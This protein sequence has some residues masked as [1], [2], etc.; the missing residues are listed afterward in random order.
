MVCIKKDAFIMLP[1]NYRSLKKLQRSLIHLGTILTLLIAVNLDTSTSYAAP[2]SIPNVRQQK[3]EI[4]SQFG[5]G[6]GRTAAIAWHEGYLLVDAWGTSQTSIYDLTNLS[7]PKLLA[8]GLQTPAQR[9][10]FNFRDGALLWPASDKEFHVL[11]GDLYF[12]HINNSLSRK[13]TSSGVEQVTDQSIHNRLDIPLGGEFRNAAIEYWTRESSYYP[14]RAT[15]FWYES[16]STQSELF[17]DNERIASW[18]HRGQTGVN[19][20]GVTLG[21]YLIYMAFSV[22][23]VNNDSPGKGI[24]IYDMR[25][26]LDNP[27]TPPTLIGY[28][29]AMIGGYSPVLWGG[30]GKLKAF[31]GAAQW[32]GLGQF[33]TVDITDLSNPTNIKS[34]SLTGQGRNNNGIQ[35]QRA[36]DEYMYGAYFKINMETNQFE[37]LIFEQ[38]PNAPFQQVDASQ[39]ALPVGNLVFFGGYPINGGAQGGVTVVASQEE[40]DTRGP[41]V[42]FHIPRA[43]EVNYHRKAPLSVL[44]H[45]TLRQSTIRM[46]ETIKIRPVAPNGSLGEPIDAVVRFSFDNIMTIDPRPLGSNRERWAADT[47]YE[48]EFVANGIEDAAGN[49]MVQHK[50]RFSTGPNLIGEAGGFDSNDTPNTGTPTSQLTL[51]DV[52]VNPGT[53]MNEDSRVNFSIS[54]SGGNSTKTFTWSFDDGSTQITNSGQVSHIYANPGTYRISVEVNDGTTPRFAFANI[55]VLPNPEVSRTSANSAEM[56][57]TSDGL[58]LFTVNPDNDSITLINTSNNQLIGELRDIC[59]APTSI[60]RDINNMVWVACEKDDKVLILNSSGEKVKTI[61]LPW[62]TRPSAIV[63]I[64]DSVYLTTLLRAFVP[65]LSH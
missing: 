48:V 35:Y 40:P 1:T 58:T 12:H 56:A 59:R 14:F 28:S 7:I 45:E 25:P 33:H 11:D 15:Q 51:G 22:A 31:F 19:G 34:V 17:F 38:E 62:G 10:Y 49:G 5:V 26:S 47:T 18:N 61:D 42:G 36:Q 29:P 13:I 44:I 41:E 23:T 52:S 37:Q 39:F 43:G 9:H 57:L 6:N 3:G 53:L 50:F 63:T 21:H 30:K 16:E 32:G 55:L 4:L 8:S 54:A 2:P 60:A 65:L 46:G 64:G 24:A 27:G 20:F